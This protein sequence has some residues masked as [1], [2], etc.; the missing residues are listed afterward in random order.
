MEDKETIHI[1]IAQLMS[2]DD[3]IL[4]LRGKL[5]A[6][7]GEQQSGNTLI[8][9]KLDKALEVLKKMRRDNKDLSNRLSRALKAQSEALAARSAAE[10][11]VELL[12]SALE[13]LEEYPR[14]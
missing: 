10:R 13:A 11:Q 5:D 3:E 9:S 8:L 2:K 12:S 4:Q 6:L 7:Q 14:R 1:L